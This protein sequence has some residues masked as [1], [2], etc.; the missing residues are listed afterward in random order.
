M[1]K[2]V[3]FLTLTLLLT[4]TVGL[5]AEEKEFDAHAT[6]F[7]YF[8]KDGDMDFH[9]GNLILGAT[10]N[11]GAEIG[12]A[13]YAASRIKDGDAASW[14]EEW[15][16]LAQRVEK[17]GLEALKGKHKKSAADQLLRAAYYYRI[18]LLAMQANN[19]ELKKRGETCRV[20]MQKAGTLL[21]PPLE[22]IEIP[23]ED[24]V[25]PV[26]FRKADNSGKPAKTLVMI[27]GGETFIEDL[28]FYI[29]PQAHARGYNFMTVD[30]PGQGMMPL[31][32][33]VFRTDTNMAMKKVI[34]YALS[35]PDVD[36]NRLASYGISGGG[37]FVP[38][39]AMHDSRIKAIAMNSG[40]VDAQRLFRTM[41]ATQASPENIAEW[42]SFHAGVVKSICW[43]Y[44]VN[45]PAE[46]VEANRGN[47]FDG[48]KIKAPAL[49]IVGEGEYRSKEVQRQ[50]QIAMESFRDKRSCLV[51]TPSDEGATNH[52]IM[53]NRS[54]VGQVLFDWLDEVL[55]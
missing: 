9:F 15:Y 51:V 40:V 26:F 34:D 16:K 21:N 7:S 41:P 27:G 48:S 29:E 24:T 17:R 35:R 5:F 18:S 49:L 37:L 11:G 36:R 30:L 14:Q 4:A 54:L 55:K 8:F 33:Q 47:T 44:G 31:S 6:T 43:R 22:Y 45:N 39:A 32:G 42:S 19:P 20:L 50:Q 13:F 46:L 2:R 10:R 23:F 25:L 28:F 53:E 1:I 3:S 38:Q 52:C 12:E